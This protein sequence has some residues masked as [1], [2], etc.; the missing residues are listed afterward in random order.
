MNLKVGVL[1]LLVLTILTRIEIVAQTPYFIPT[2]AVDVIGDVSDG[3]ILL[4]PV[5][6]DSATNFSSGLLI[7]DAQG[8]PV[9]FKPSFPVSNDTIFRQKFLVDFNLQPDGSFSF[10]ERLGFTGGTLYFMDD[11]L[12]ITDSLKC[13]SHHNLDP[14]DAI[15]DEN[16]ITHYLC[17]DQRIVDASGMTT[18]TGLSGSDSAVIEGNVIERIDQNGN[19]LWTWF[20]LD[21]YTLDDTYEE[22]FANP[23]FVD[24]THYNSIEI[25]TDGNY[26]VSARN[27]HEIAKINSTTGDIMWQLGGKNNDFQLI[28]DTVWFTGQHD[29]RRL[30]NGDVALFDNATQTSNGVAR[31]IQYK[32]DTSNLTATLTW[33]KRMESGHRSLFIGSNRLLSNGNR[34]INW[35]GASPFDQTI[36]M[37]EVN[38]TGNVVMSLD[39][40]GN[41]ISYRTIKIDLPMVTFPEITCT[42]QELVA[43]ISDYYLW[44]NGDT[45]E[46]ITVS[47]TGTYYV[48]TEESGVYKKSTP[49][50]VANLND[51]CNTVSTNQLVSDNV[52]RIYPQPA[53]DQLTISGNEQ[54]DPEF[55]QLLSSTGQEIPIK[56]NSTSKHKLT[57]NIKSLPIGI[58][59]LVYNNTMQK[60]VIQ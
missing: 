22:Y 15:R 18:N 30:P 17:F 5:S 2:P 24:H 1:I 54:I 35:G 19:V 11:D 10:F 50:M 6:L 32:L 49:Y 23:Q 44:S 41:F 31:A 52:I 16:G 25:D 55:I 21:H 47:D 14:H 12:L 45:T 58:Y 38:S 53:V 59:F 33:E 9:L 39:F 40:P 3:Y 42:N 34:I 28:G 27:L 4:S 37:Q 57:A 51:V 26:I 60:V 56:W 46:R 43:P 8:E 7:L 20:S 36:S 29:A 13:E 48:W